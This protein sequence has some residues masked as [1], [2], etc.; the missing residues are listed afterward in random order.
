VLSALASVA[1]GEVVEDA[2]CIDG[3]EHAASTKS[4]AAKLLHVLII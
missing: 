3:D 2:V 1:W 4:A